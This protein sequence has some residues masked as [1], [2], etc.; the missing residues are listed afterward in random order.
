MRLLACLS[1]LATFVCP[2]PAAA[3]SFVRAPIGD[4]GA[5]FS[6]VTL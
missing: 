6:G 4:V 1:L 3:G 2:A 5:P